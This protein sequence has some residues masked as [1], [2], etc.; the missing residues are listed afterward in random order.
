IEMDLT[1]EQMTET[2]PDL[3]TI[4]TKTPPQTMSQQPITRQGEQGEDN[5][6]VDV[7]SAMNGIMD[8]LGWPSPCQSC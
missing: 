3:V 1:V 5:T 6:F 7:N 2:R 8:E 4:N